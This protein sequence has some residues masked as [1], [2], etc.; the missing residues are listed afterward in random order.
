MD[1]ETKR[2]AGR[3]SILTPEVQAKIC[4]ALKAGNFRTVAAEWAGVPERVF[5]EWM[6]KGKD[7]PE[8]AYAE[9][10]RAVIE[11]EKQAEIRAVTL[12]MKA[13][14]NDPKHAQWWLSHRFPARWA[15]QERKRIR[16]EISGRNGGPIQMQSAIDVSKLSREQVGLLEQIIVKTAE[17]AAG[18]TDD[19]TIDGSDEGG[20]A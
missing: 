16:A 13:A 3:P 20:E 7:N 19:T 1:G 18:D 8:S 12:I 11:A 14:E 6:K 4:S 9:F 17:D 5:F 10:R 2:G 15:D